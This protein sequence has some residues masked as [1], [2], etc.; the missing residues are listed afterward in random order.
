MDITFWVVKFPDTVYSP[1]YGENDPEELFVRYMR[2]I[3]NFFM[4]FAEM[5]EEQAR[6]FVSAVTK[7]PTV[8]VRR[9]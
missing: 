9:Q 3:T 1:M 2:G 5:T 6:E 8:E 7:V 4:S